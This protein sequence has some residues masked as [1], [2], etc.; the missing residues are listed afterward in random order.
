LPVE[1]RE[2]R[3][4][5]AVSGKKLRPPSRESFST[6]LIALAERARR[7]HSEPLKTLAHLIDKEWLL[8]SW[9]RIR[10]GA[11]YGVDAVSAEDYESNLDA[12]L[13]DLMVKLRTNKY[14]PKPVKRVYIPKPDGRQ[15]P[16]GLPTVQDKIAQRAVGL[17]LSAIYEQDFMPMSFGFRQGRSAHQAIEGVK[18]EIAQGKVSWVVDADI[19]CFFDEMDHR[20]LMRF[21]KHRVADKAILRLIGKWLKAGIMEEGKLTK[22]STG[23]PQGGV[24]SPILANIYLHYVIDLWVAKVVSK[25]LNGEM[26]NFR[27]ADDIL[28]CFQYR[29]DAIRFLRALC[30]RLGKFGLQL[31]NEKT[32]L[33][34]FGRFA[35]RDRK[36]RN[37]KRATFGFLG[38]TFYNRLSKAGKYTVGCRT[39]SRRLNNAM[40]RVTTWCKENR[41]QNVEWQA[42][43]LNAMLR[44]H[45]NYYG[46]TGNFKSVA[47]FYRHT[48]K[49]WHR[50]LSRRSQR[51]YIKWERFVRTL[52]KYPLIK[53]HL[54][55]SVYAS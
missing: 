19:S 49:M 7:I 54:P 29:K 1:G 24:V 3:P 43:Y 27:Y 18:A 50:Y 21:L 15:R 39:Q 10:K 48:V 36:I 16:L 28:F 25:H 46:V 53:P 33:Y 41:H 31:N 34:R 2:Q 47:A 45:Y 51:A 23:A 37:E 40:N 17:I 9:K 32:R 38:F 52:E 13:D 20:W 6:K 26:H 22:A 42:R 8:E 4:A 11:A 44:G 5:R 14:K 12:N 35:E 30:F 55:H